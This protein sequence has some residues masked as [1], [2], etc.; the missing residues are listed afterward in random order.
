MNTHM[1]ISVWKLLPIGLGTCLG[2]EHKVILYISTWGIANL[3]FIVAIWY[4]ILC[5]IE[6]WRLQFLYILANT[7]PFLLSSLFS[8]LPVFFPS[9]HYG[10]PKECEAVSHHGFDINLIKILSFPHSQPALGCK[11]W[12]S[13]TA[14]TAAWICEVFYA[15][16]SL[17][18]LCLL[19]TCKLPHPPIPRDLC[20]LS[21]TNTHTF[22]HTG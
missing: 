13:E 22:I 19:L 16:I 15:F 4:Y 9:I 17:L 20:S 18:H 3:S 7:V 1:H 5:T 21:Q 6:V 14:S 12:L 11:D 2:M 8:F 10:H